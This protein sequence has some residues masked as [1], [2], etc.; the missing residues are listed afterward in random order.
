MCKLTAC[1]LI[2]LTVNCISHCWS[3]YQVS[4]AVAI[5]HTTTPQC[6]ITLLSY[7]FTSWLCSLPPKAGQIRNLYWHISAHNCMVPLVK[8][9]HRDKLL[10][11]TKL[12]RHCRPSNAF[13]GVQVPH[14]KV[15]R[16]QIF[17]NNLEQ[18]AKLLV[19]LDK[20]HMN[21][22]T[23][24]LQHLMYMGTMSSIHLIWGQQARPV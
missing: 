1:I 12:D 14:E 18:C 13:W 19:T 11:A 8:S 15:Y 9:I 7:K 4:K 22:L 16:L 24:Q 10:C 5:Q 6:D 3:S 20:R 23:K 17:K 2:L 21:S